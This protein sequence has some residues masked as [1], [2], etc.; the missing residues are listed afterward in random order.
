MN[1]INDLVEF[2]ADR[3]GIIECHRDTTGAL[4][5]TVTLAVDPAGAVISVVG[6]DINS[7]LDSTDKAYK[8][9]LKNK[10]VVPLHKNQGGN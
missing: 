8:K 10:S 4:R 2:L 3:N 6:A 1:H 7:V 5:V 9:Y